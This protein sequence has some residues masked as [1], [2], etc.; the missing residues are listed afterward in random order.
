M[1][2]NK[3]LKFYIRQLIKEVMQ[4]V[5]LPASYKLAK[6]KLDKELIVLADC[7]HEDCP[8]ELRLIKEALVKSDRKVETFFFDIGKMSMREGFS[9]MVK[10]MKLYKKAGT[11]IICSYFLPVASCKKNKDT[12][13][14]NV[15]HGC[16]AMKK[17]GYDAVDDIPERYKGNPYTNTDYMCVTGSACVRAF[18]SAMK[19]DKAKVIPVGASITDIYYDEQFLEKCKEKFARLYPEG[20]GKEVILWAP[21]FRDNALF[22]GCCGEEAI[23]SIIKDE[24]LSKKYCVIKS[25]HPNMLKK[26]NKKNTGNDTEKKKD[27]VMSTRELLTVADILITDYSSVW[28]EYLIFDKPVIFFAPDYRKYVEKRGFYLEYE[29]LPGVK[30]LNEYDGKILTK[31]LKNKD[32]LCRDYILQRKNIFDIYMGGCDGNATNRIL[33]RL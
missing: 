31:T 2:K 12:K 19:Y 33:E 21:T 23:D 32:Y 10:F 28:F 17:F 11:V 6:G 20:V 7:H 22:A 3:N 15:W 1:K 30:I 9:Q 8:E 14:I 25:L 4:H 29:G 27:K 24:E 13:V 26:A 18:E 5:I 16:G